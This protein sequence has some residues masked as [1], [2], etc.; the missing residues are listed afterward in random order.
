VL[1]GNL[2]PAT[3]PMH[4]GAHPTVL[5][6]LSASGLEKKH[7]PVH[8]TDFKSAWFYTSTPLR[9]KWDSSFSMVNTLP[10]L[11]VSLPTFYSQDF[12]HIR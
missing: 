8:S 7:N 9:F 11:S 5:Q 6:L 2:L 12:H 10:T 4:S 1:V 3:L